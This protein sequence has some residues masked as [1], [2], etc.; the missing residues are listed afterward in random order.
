MK[1]AIP[2]AFML[3]ALIISCAENR[4]AKRSIPNALEILERI[5]DRTVNASLLHYENKTS[6]WSL[7]DQLYSGFMVSFYPDSTLK[8]K[9]GILN[10]K[11]QDQAVRWYPDG[12]L[13]QVANYHQ[14]KLHGEKKNVVI[15][16]KPYLNC[17]FKLSFRKG[18]RRTKAMVSLW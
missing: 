1:C 5:P 3:S 7:N 14:G 15:R 8:E 12:E 13:K 18:T 4:E 9:T 17:S 2:I 6:L 16:F 11:K 10:G